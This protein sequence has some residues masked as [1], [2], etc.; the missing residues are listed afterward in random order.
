MNNVI[1]VALAQRGGG[2]GRHVRL[3]SDIIVRSMCAVESRVK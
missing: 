2:N 1:G 3:L